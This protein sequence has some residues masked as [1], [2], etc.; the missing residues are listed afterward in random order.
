MI[1][2]NSCVSA[3][4][5]EPQ[6]NAD[7]KLCLLIIDKDDIAHLQGKDELFSRRKSTANAKFQ[8]FISYL[9]SA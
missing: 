8:V 6:Q 1:K 3:K 5:T 7:Q 4:K 2:M 9:M